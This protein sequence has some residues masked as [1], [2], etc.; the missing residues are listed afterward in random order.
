VV[1]RASIVTNIK[2]FSAKV[3]NAIGHGSPS[4]K[5]FAEEIF[6]LKPVA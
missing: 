6:D 3:P 1:V 2:L 4:V 5:G